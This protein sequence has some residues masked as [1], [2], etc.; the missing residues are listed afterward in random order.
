MKNKLIDNNHE[1]DF[2]RTSENYAK[3]R[4]IYPK[5]MCDELIGYEFQLLYT[6]YTHS[7]A[8]LSRCGT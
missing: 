7:C 4:D 2:G 3:Y 6:G 5:S 8:V 1:F